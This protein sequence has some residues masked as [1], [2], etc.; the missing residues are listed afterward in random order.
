MSFLFDILKP[1]SNRT[2]IADAGVIN[3]QYPYWRLRILY[4]IFIGYALYYFTRKSL[5]FV[6]PAL[7]NDPN[8]D[9]DKALLGLLST[10]FAF[11]YGISKFFSG[12]LSDHSTPRYFMAFGLI[13]TGITNIFFGMSSSLL[14]FAILWGLNG[15]F[16]GFGAPP[17]VRLLTQ[18]YSHSERG[19]WWSYWSVSHNVGSFLIPW[20]I[21]LSLYFFS[22]DWGWRFAMLVPGIVCIFGGF[23]LINRLRDNP[24]SLGLPS[25]EKFR[26]DYSQVIAGTD[27]KDA[28]LSAWDVFSIY[29]LK[30][31]SIWLLAAAY[32]FVY[33][34][35]AG[36]IEWGVFFLSETKE[37]GL[38]A[39]IACISFFE[40]GGFCGNL[41]AGWA[42]D[43]LFEAKRGPVNALFALAI[44]LS[45]FLFW[46]IPQ[47]SSLL[48]LLAFFSLSLGQVLQGS[49]P[50]LFN[51]LQGIYP[52]DYLAVFLLG[53]AVYGPQMLIGVAAAEASHKDAVATS[54]GFV[55]LT[56]Y[57]GA[58][59]AG[60]P[61][62]K[63]ILVWGWSG[64]FVTLISCG[65]LSLLVL[66][67]LWNDGK[68]E[69]KQLEQATA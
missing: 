9:I 57:M 13:L 24:Q 39:A 50:F 52:L 10:V 69:E 6:G 2:E 26:N 22:G 27:K 68:T 21:A 20:V 48:E 18:W 16:Q 25:I 66:F 47:G 3:K 59:F 7:V 5:T 28:K 49:A 58:A 17:C 61:L 8:I 65:L 33:T 53:F 54:N 34:V 38:P 37:Y 14:L 4:S 31:R 30:N 40:V 32:F 1:A 11:S 35:R 64:F 29:I 62:G 63:I 23:F 56:G 15:W 36:I 44:I 67:P 12:V 46:N 19:S 60:Y 51:L 41:F 45:V 55:S 43:R 42:S